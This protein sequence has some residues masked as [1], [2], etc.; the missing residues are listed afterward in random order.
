MA[1]KLRRQAGMITNKMLAHRNSRRDPE[2]LGTGAGSF[3]R[4]LGAR[5]RRGRRR[6]TGTQGECEYEE[7]HSCGERT[8]VHGLAME[9]RHEAR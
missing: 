2:P 6:T 9:C 8:G 3:K 4:L 7:H 5:P 1:L